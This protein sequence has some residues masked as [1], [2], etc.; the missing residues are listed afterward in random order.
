MDYSDVFLSNALLFKMGFGLTGHSDGVD[1]KRLAE[2][3]IEQR[4]RRAD[5]YVEVRKENIYLTSGSFL[6]TKG[7]FTAQ[8]F[9]DE[10][11]LLVSVQSKQKRNS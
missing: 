5:L 2:V 10:F 9:K 1:I 6:A 4:L 7:A 11:Y 3:W 8:D